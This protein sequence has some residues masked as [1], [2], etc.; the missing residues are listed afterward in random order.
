M[1]FR[2]GVKKIISIFE[3]YFLRTFSDKNEF[4]AP[5]FKGNLQSYRLSEKKGSFF[6]GYH[7]KTPFSADDSKIL[8]HRFFSSE[9]SIDAECQPIDIGFFKMDENGVYSKEFFKIGKTT[10]WSWQQGSM[11]QWNPKNPNNEIIYNN[12]VREEYGAVIQDIVSGEIT[13]QYSRAMYSVSDDG[14]LGVSINF[15]R[16]ARLRPGYGYNF[17]GDKDKSISSPDNDGIFLVNLDTGEDKLLISLAEM[18]ATLTED[19]EADHYVN[20]TNFSP[21][22]SKLVYF[23]II[24]PKRSRRSIQLGIYDLRSNTNEIIEKD[25]LVSHYCWKNSNQIIV[26]TRD[27]NLNWYYTLYTI[28]TKEKVDLK[29]P[30]R[31]DGHPMSS[32]FSENIIITDTTPDKKRNHHICIVDIHTREVQE[33]AAVFTPLKYNGP[34]RCD[35]HPRWNRSGNMI[36]IDAADRGKRELLIFSFNKDQN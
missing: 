26:T 36:C 8:A 7:D 27:K 18:A 5:A 33:L 34:V 2:Q 35:S 10:T 13:R 31:L 14:L 21:D 4:I 19:I 30:F 15:S 20:H 29:L 28:N 22:N 11:L 12:L 3:L 23:H 32:P 25:R 17:M 16:L 9:T 6:F 1:K 24:Q